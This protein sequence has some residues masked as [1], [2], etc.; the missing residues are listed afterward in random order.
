[1]KLTKFLLSVILIS[2]FAHSAYAAKKA[3]KRTPA[4]EEQNIYNLPISQSEIKIIEVGPVEKKPHEY[5]FTASN[6]TPKNFNLPSY[7]SDSS[8]FGREGIPLVSV[9][10]IT[11]SF[12]VGSS[13]DISSKFG[14][15]YMSLERSAPFSGSSAHETLNLFSVRIGAEYTA[16]KLM[17]FNLEPAVGLFILP[18][19]IAA[20]RTELDN[21]VSA[22][23]FPIEGSL[24]LLYHSPQLSKLVGS[25]DLIL[26]LG[27]DDV[28]GSV[29]GANLNGLGVQGILRLRM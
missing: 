10:Y 4:V 27:I 25:S 20:S 13:G 26:G 9:N 23:G 1:M 22:Y 14:L 15:S 28:Y 29:S 11:K 8:D 18:T 24:D 17:P 6:W 16:R 21:G 19:W 12:D 3:K 5:E 2:S 7:L